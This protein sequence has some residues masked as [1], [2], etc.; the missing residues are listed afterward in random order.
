MH[1]QLCMNFIEKLQYYVLMDAIRYVKW[2]RY[3]FV[4]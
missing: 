1:V 3:T 4:N 2:H